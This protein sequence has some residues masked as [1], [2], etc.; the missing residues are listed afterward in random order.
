MGCCILA[1]GVARH[2]RHLRLGFGTSNELCCN[3]GVKIRILFKAGVVSSSRQVKYLQLNL[4]H[5][6]LAA[7]NFDDGLHALHDLTLDHKLAG[8]SSAEEH[9]ID[10]EAAICEASLDPVNKASVNLLQQQ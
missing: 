5:G 9:D 4:G 10:L 3:M 6:L 2:G 7:A 8:E 1:I